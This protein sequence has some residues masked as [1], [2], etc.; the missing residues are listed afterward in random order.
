MSSDVIRM[1][2]SLYAEHGRALVERP[3][4]W[5]RQLM[6]ACLVVGVPLVSVPLVMAS[7]HVVLEAR[8]NRALLKDMARFPTLRVPELA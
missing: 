7:L 6:A 1:A 8:F 5:R 3:W 2:T 4:R